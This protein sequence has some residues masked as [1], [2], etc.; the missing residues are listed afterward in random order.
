MKEKKIQNGCLN[1]FTIIILKYQHLF[2]ITQPVVNSQ[3]QTGVSQILTTL[4]EDS[5]YVFSVIIFIVT[6]S[7][8]LSWHFYR[9]QHE[10]MIR[11]TFCPLFFGR[12]LFRCSQIIG[13]SFFDF[14]IFIK[15]CKTKSSSLKFKVFQIQFNFEIHWVR[16]FTRMKKILFRSVLVN[17]WHFLRWEKN[18][19]KVDVWLMKNQLAVLEINFKKLF[20]ILLHFQLSAWL[21]WYVDRIES[22]IKKKKSM[23][24]Q[25]S[26]KT[27]HSNFLKN[28]R[29]SIAVYHG[30]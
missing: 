20:K 4:K 15:F 25:E 17:Y 9:H 30:F 5:I 11:E 26:L 16:I 21:H 27:T 24:L 3:K 28:I 10:D 14:L 12:S 22:Y 7:P 18:I 6:H 1:L 13:D 2:R 23:V 29:V 19:L 8:S